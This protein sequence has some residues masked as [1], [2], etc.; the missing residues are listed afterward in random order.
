MD[1]DVIG[2]DEGQ[3]Y[4]DIVEFSNKAANSGK[5]VIMSALN[6]TFEQTG[7]PTIMEL[8]PMCEKVKKLSAICKVC[9]AN[10]NYSFKTTPTNSKG[11]I[12]IG[13]SESYIPV[14]REC[15]IDK[16]AEKDALNE[17]ISE[18][19][20]AA[21]QNTLMTDNEMQTPV[22]AKEVRHTSNF[23]D[24]NNQVAH[25][26]TLISP[27]RDVRQFTEGVE[28]KLRNRGD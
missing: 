28:A 26:N 6:G 19:T 4:A 17:Q 13:G 12:Q 20:A 8:I 21:E 14:C 22:L 3:F 18:S 25:N 24:N 27:E 1:F 11:L 2:I 7:F 10:A 9:S 5:I 23:S 16:Q 15:L